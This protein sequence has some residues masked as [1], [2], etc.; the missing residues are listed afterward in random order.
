MAPWGQLAPQELQ[1]LRIQTALTHQDLQTRG[2]AKLEALVQQ[3]IRGGGL[4]MLT[5]SV[6]PEEEATQELLEMLAPLQLRQLLLLEALEA[7][8]AQA[9]EL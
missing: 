3:A 2:L 5:L 7:R 6:P 9:E 8:V 4:Q 1:L